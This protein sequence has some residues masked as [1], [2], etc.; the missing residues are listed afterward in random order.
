[1][2]SNWGTILESHVTVS[3]CAVWLITVKARG[4]KKSKSSQERNNSSDLGV[5]NSSPFLFIWGHARLFT[6]FWVTEWVN[7]YIFLSLCGTT[8]KG[9]YNDLCTWAFCGANKEETTTGQKLC[10]PTLTINNYWEW[11]GEV[12]KM[13]RRK[14]LEEYHLPLLGLKRMGGDCSWSDSI[15]KQQI[16][17]ILIHKHW[18]EQCEW[19][20]L[21]LKL[22]KILFP[23]KICLSQLIPM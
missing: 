18:F 16:Q 7:E 14:S 13:T 19:A 20:V 4:Q 11:G 2:K 21:H 6:A 15:D 17:Q 12:R 3:I 1:M 22:A 8:L 10:T 5:H 23:D 9:T